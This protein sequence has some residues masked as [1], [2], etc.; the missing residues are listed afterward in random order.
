MC[1]YQTLTFNFYF[2]KKELQGVFVFAAKPTW[3]TAPRSQTLPPGGKASFRCEGNAG[4]E[5]TLAWFVNG[6]PF[7]GEI[8]SCALL[9]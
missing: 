5:T 7:E 2:L 3:W 4:P 8:Q 1:F 9:N 6:V